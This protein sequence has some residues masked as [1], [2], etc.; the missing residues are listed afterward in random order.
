MAAYGISH[1]AKDSEF[2][3]FWAFLKLGGK[4]KLKNDRKDLNY[5]PTINETKS[6]QKLTE[7]YS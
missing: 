2:Q 6:T 1:L 5:L 3:L 4:K 7:E